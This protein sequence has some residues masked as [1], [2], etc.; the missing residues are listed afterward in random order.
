M[1]SFR[2]KLVLVWL[3]N[4]VIKFDLQVSIVLKDV[5]DEAPRFTSSN[6]TTVM[7][8]SPLNSVVH[9]VKAVDED[10]GRN[11]YVEYLLNNEKST[12]SLG[13]VDGLLRVIANVDREQKSNYTLKVTAKDRG[14]PSKSSNQLLFIKVQDRN[15]HDPLFDSRQYS[16]AVPENASVGMSVLQVRIHYFPLCSFSKLLL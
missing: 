2:L 10:E 3:R 9:T 14:D 11:G 4:N 7:E 5:N 6:E 13:S 8:N 12:F 15:D 16:A 1:L